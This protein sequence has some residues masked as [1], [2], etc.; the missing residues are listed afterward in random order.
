M[1]LVMNNNHLNL[2]TVLLDPSKIKPM[3]IIGESLG[4]QSITIGPGDQ[5][6]YKEA[7]PSSA[8]HCVLWMNTI[9]DTG[10]QLC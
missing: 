5:A 7:L 2:G 1:N 9:V 6:D 8:K 10:D 3:G 4:L